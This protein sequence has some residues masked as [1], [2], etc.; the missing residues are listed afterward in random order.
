MAIRVGPTVG[1]KTD[2]DHIETRH[3]AIINHYSINNYQY[4]NHT[5]TSRAQT[6]DAYSGQSSWS[7][8][9]Y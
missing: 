3:V 1:S 8:L 2:S 7:V 4:I 6:V 5:P 9:P